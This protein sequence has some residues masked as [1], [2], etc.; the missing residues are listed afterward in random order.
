[1]SYGL[2][3]AKLVLSLE[4]EVRIASGM[5]VGQRVEQYDGSRFCVT[6]IVTPEQAARL[7]PQ[8]GGQE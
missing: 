5:T 7:R 1:M 6:W 8:D 3:T 2:E 4:R